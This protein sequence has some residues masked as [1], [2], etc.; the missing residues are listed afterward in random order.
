MK[1]NINILFK[2][3]NTDERILKSM[4]SDVEHQYNSEELSKAMNRSGLVQKEVQV[5][6]KN[7]Q[8]FT[9]KQ[10]VRASEAQSSSKQPKAQE[11]TKDKQVSSVSQKGYRVSINNGDVMI[12]TMTKPISEHT[13]GDHLVSQFKGT[14]GKV[15]EVTREKSNGTTAP[16][17]KSVKPVI[18]EQLEETPQSNP[19]TT[20]QHWTKVGTSQ[21]AKSQIAQML[22]SGKSRED[23]IAEFK[24][25]GVTWKESDNAGINWM[26][27]AMAMNKHLT[28]GNAEIQDS[29]KGQQSSSKNE[30][31]K[32]EKPKSVIGSDYT[33]LTTEK[34]SGT[35]EGEAHNMMVGKL[36]SKGKK[37]PTEK[38]IKAAANDLKDKAVKTVISSYNQD[39]MVHQ[40]AMAKQFTKL[41]GGNMDHMTTEGILRD[42][43]SSSSS[44]TQEQKCNAMSK[45]LG[46]NY[47]T[48]T[49]DTVAR[50]SNNTDAAVHIRPL[51]RGNFEVTFTY[52]DGAGSTKETYDSIDSVKKAADKWIDKEDDYYKKD[53]ENN[54]KKTKFT[55][56]GGKQEPYSW[57]SKEENEKLSSIPKYVDKPVEQWGDYSITQGGYHENFKS[58]DELKSALK[59]RGL[60]SSL[61]NFDTKKFKSDDGYIQ[62]DYQ[63][64][65]VYAYPEVNPEWEK[66]YDEAAKAARER[67]MNKG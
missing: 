14:D 10:W 30:S 42:S 49:N 25:Q 8:T 18:K 9:R 15:Y 47:T 16:K 41:A 62:N 60:P 59:Y 40:L 43:L 65:G 44:C 20:K 50:Y 51:S 53:K 66:A 17:V 35:I 34:E 1:S 39:E 57:M 4:D 46:S 23:C 33:Q 13:V 45:L 56:F 21:E 64:A 29:S 28:S 5:Q 19:K 61:A 7:G 11:D 52:G 58:I 36:G 37:K 32:A 2:Q 31:K 54:K 24:S 27:A 12:N 26:R 55:N 6:G 67:R 22:A 3:G 63:N 48:T 38:E